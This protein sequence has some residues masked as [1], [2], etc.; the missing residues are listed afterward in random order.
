[1]LTPTQ[2]HATYGHASLDKSKR[3]G[4]VRAM[5]ICASAKFRT[6]VVN[7]LQSVYEVDFYS[8]TEAALP[9]L[10]R[11]VTPG[12]IVLDYRL[13][14]SHSREFMKVKLQEEKLQDVPILLTGTVEEEEFQ[15]T[16]RMACRVGYLQRPF[17]KS[18]LRDAACRLVDG[19]I[20]DRW[21]RL[22]ERQ[23]QAL[24]NSASNFR[25]IEHKVKKGHPLNMCDNKES[26]A[27]LMDEVLDGNAKDLIANV[28]DHNNH[29]YV[30]SVKVATLMTL[31]GQAIGIKGDE[32]LTITT[33]GMLMDVGKVATRQ[34]LLNTPETLDKS[35]MKELKKHVLF[36]HNILEESE[37]VG[38]GIKV[39][40]EQHHEKLDGTGYP[41]GLK[42]K[43]LNELARLSTISDIFCALTDKRPYKPAF[44]FEQSIN[45][46][47]KMEGQIDPFLLALFKQVV[48]LAFDKKATVH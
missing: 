20:E 46:L 27:P 11:G 33:G 40:A 32:L 17:L 43:E 6:E 5:V 36:S 12:V 21:K 9:A 29:T 34:D 41:R 37:N 47:E 3:P 25:T 22:P 13:M 38:E 2:T 4:L 30:H 8:S 31:F 15:K 23:K 18:Q 26:C 44:S 39:I 35:Q 14:V 10:R 24:Q 42:G 7:S 16:V 19:P 45:V 28:Q 1:M 48:S